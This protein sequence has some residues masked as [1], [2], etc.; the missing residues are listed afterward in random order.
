[1][2]ITPANL[3]Q[4]PLT[5]TIPLLRKLG[6]REIRFDNFSVTLE[7]HPPV[8][9]TIPSNA[10]VETPAPLPECVCDHPLEDHSPEGYCLQGCENCAPKEKATTKKDN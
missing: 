7:T 2:T 8:E 1:M 10:P 3:P 4:L 6:I 5:D 9:G